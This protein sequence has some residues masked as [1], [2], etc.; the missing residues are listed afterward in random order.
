MDPNREDLTETDADAPL[1]SRRNFLG[2]TIGGA[3]ALAGGAL[4]AVTGPASVETS[5][6]FS[7]LRVS[8]NLDFP[9]R[10]SRA[11]SRS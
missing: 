7:A 1:L 5:G 4:A 6:A 11:L 3:A 8:L 9:S 10:L 2:T